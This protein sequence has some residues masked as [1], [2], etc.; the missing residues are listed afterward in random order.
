MRVHHSG[1]LSCEFFSAYV[2]LVI[3][4]REYTI[5]EAKEFTFNRFFQGDSTSLGEIT[6]GNFMKAIKQCLSYK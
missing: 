5:G 2:N 3:R 1:N 4:A 6:Y